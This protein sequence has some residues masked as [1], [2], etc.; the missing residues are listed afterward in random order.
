MAKLGHWLASFGVVALLAVQ[1]SCKESV[2]HSD[3]IQVE[4]TFRSVANGIAE[5]DLITQLGEP[6]GRIAF[7]PARGT[8]QYSATTDPT[9]VQ[10]FR[11]LD[12]VKNSPHSELRFLRARARTN[13]ILIFVQGTVHG[14]FYFGETGRLEDKIVV[15]S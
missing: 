6:T 8:F 14:Y 5:A 3:E 11:T 2:Y 4:K 9:S 12:E 1:L 10:E 15:V 13:T 7:N